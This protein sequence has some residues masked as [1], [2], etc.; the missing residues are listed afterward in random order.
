MEQDHGYFTNL[1]YI[2]CGRWLQQ[3]AVAKSKFCQS[4]LIM[5]I[6]LALKHTFWHTK[7]KDL[8]KQQVFLPSK[9][10]REN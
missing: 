2:F 3:K 4:A 10:K 6:L 7:A 5:P 8:P 1:Y 9:S